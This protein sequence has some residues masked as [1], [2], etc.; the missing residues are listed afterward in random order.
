MGAEFIEPFSRVFER[1]VL[2]EARSVGVPFF[3]EKA[4]KAWLPT[5]SEVPDGVLAYESC[6]IFIES[7]AGLFDTSVMVAGHSTIFSH[8]TKA[9][10]K[11]A[12]QAWAA[13]EGARLSSAAPEIVKNAPVDFLIVVTN[14][15]L[16]AGK[17][18]SVAGMYPEGKFAPPNSKAAQ[19]LPLDHIYVMSIEDYESLM[20]ATR[21]GEINLPEFLHGCVHRDAHPGTMLM[22]M[23]QHLQE[24]KIPTRLSG[25]VHDST[26]A[27]SRRLEKFLPKA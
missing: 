27:A 23:R 21:L 24:M 19:T 5:E 11:A 6:N 13:N 7:K 1:H 18:S 8:K 12:N 4:I 25:L 26:E 14:K 20:S 17:G 22:F 2:G 16:S 10:L 9:L 3:D 15:E